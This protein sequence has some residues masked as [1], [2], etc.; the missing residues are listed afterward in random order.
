[1]LFDDHAGH[2][3]HFGEAAGENGGGGHSA[4]S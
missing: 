4:F 3:L 1:L 2:A